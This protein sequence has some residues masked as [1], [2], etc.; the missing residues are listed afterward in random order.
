[1]GLA[2][3]RTHGRGL[4]AIAAYLT[5]TLQRGQPGG[6]RTNRHPSHSYPSRSA[7][8]VCALEYCLCYLARLWRVY[9]L[10]HLSD[11]ARGYTVDDFRM[12]ALLLASV[13]ISPHGSSVTTAYSLPPP[14]LGCSMTACNSG[15]WE[16][17]SPFFY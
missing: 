1:M 13:L 6:A 3:R 8:A 17:Q 9:R 12:T 5:S 16:R 15:K 7:F 11:L 2:I 4:D 14:G 10:P